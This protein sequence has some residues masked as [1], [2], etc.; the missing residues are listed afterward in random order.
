M[1]IF[2]GVKYLVDLLNLKQ[3][4]AF[5]VEDFTTSWQY[6]LISLALS[7]IISV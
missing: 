5:L 2:Q 1:F 4:G 6:I 3:I 7:A